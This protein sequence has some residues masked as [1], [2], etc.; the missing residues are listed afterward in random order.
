[1]HWIARQL[2]LS[3]Q[4]HVYAIIA[5]SLLQ[6]EEGTTSHNRRETRYVF[7]L[8]DKPIFWIVG[9]IIFKVVTEEFITIKMICLT[10]QNVGL[11]NNSN[12]YLVS[13][14]LCGVVPSLLCYYILERLCQ[15]FV[16][17]INLDPAVLIVPVASFFDSFIIVGC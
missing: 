17:S 14:L 1:M 7:E 15:D 4:E 13:G 3:P 5:L 6:S 10:V 16:S 12:T 11:L 9:Q 8:S 2:R